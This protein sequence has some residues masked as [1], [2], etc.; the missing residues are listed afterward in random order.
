MFCII[1]TYSKAIL[2][3]PW[4][5]GIVALAAGLI[6][7]RY[8]I[9]LRLKIFLF[10]IG[11]LA[12][13]LFAPSMQQNKIE[14]TPESFYLRTGLWWSPHVHQFLLRDVTK[15]EIIHLQDAKGRPR[16]FMRVTFRNGS[17]DDVP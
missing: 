3:I 17:T 8:P 9:N 11:V 2:A 14:T 16:A 10:L 5:V 6:F 13:V 15:M 1:Y 7:L 12:L 4:G